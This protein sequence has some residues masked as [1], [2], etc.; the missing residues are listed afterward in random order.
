MAWATLFVGVVAFAALSAGQASKE[1]EEKLIGWQGETYQPTA[2]GLSVDTVGTPLASAN[3][4]ERKAWIQVISWKPRAFIYHNFMSD[5][6][7]KHII[8]VAHAQMKRSTVVGGKDG[9]VVDDIRTSY[10]TFLRRNQ[11]PVIK[12]IEQ[13]LAIWSQLPA[14]HQ[15]DM[16]V[17]RYG[18]TNKYGPHIDGLERVA[19]VLMYLVAPDSGGET[20]FVNSKWLSRELADSLESENVSTCA[21]GHVAY[22]PRRG[23]ALMFFDTLPDYK[24]QDQHSMHTGCPVVSGVKWNAVKWIHGKPFRDEEWQASL[25]EPFKPLPDPGE[26]ANLHDSCQMWADAG[27]CEKN[28]G[29]MMGGNIGQ[30][31]CRLACKDCEVCAPGDEKACFQ[32]NRSKGGFLQYDPSELKGLEKL[33]KQ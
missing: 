15:E 8:D 18:P 27:E 25:R 20:A 30:G 11:D 14:S 19:T 22:M 9:G 10:G 6:E 16:Q 32:R 33:G 17:L 26:C 28:P 12:A 29:Y 4:T 24:S 7:C 31:A 21:K 1:R 23:D 3:T 5:Q 13:R 2:N